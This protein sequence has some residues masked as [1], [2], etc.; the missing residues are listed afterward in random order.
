M[1]RTRALPHLNDAEDVL[2]EAE[3]H[4]HASILEQG[5]HFYLIT[6]DPF[7]E[8]IDHVRRF[9]MKKKAWLALRRSQALPLC[10]A[11][12][13]VSKIASGG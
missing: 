4:A 12:Q 7:F 5:A 3:K 13:K 11:D 9:P 1:N 10:G 6:S 2:D 8:G